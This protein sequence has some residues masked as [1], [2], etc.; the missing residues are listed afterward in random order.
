[1]KIHVTIL[2]LLLIFFCKASASDYTLNYQIIN[3]ESCSVESSF[4]MAAK[5]SPPP[6]NSHIYDVRTVVVVNLQ[7]TAFYTYTVEYDREINK[8]IVEVTDNPSEF[9]QAVMD[10]NSFRSNTTS[11]IEWD[12]IPAWLASGAGYSISSTSV[13]SDAK[14]VSI[15]G[16]TPFPV[17]PDISGSVTTLI[18]NLEQQALVHERI[19]MSVVAPRI[20]HYAK[21]SALKFLFGIKPV[22][23][24]LNFIDGSKV[25]YDVVNPFVTVPGSFNWDTAVDG[26]GNPVV[27]AYEQRGSSTDSYGG[28]NY[29]RKPHPSISF[30]CVPAYFTG[31]AGVRMVSQGRMCTYQI[32]DGDR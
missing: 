11:V 22:P 8:T 20:Y 7:T 6:N 17:T 1:M 10:Y 5:N 13:S 25:V 26:S 3:C 12:Y 4:R 16:A 15:K 2:T 28:G 30:K 24:V 14:F 32:I 21:T 31:T 18:N 27:K 29:T 23:V 19:R 9:Q